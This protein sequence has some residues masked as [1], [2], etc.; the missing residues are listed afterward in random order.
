MLAIHPPARHTS[1][2]Q[3][4]RPAPPPKRSHISVNTAYYPAK[5]PSPELSLHHD[6]QCPS[7]TQLWR[8]LR[9]ISS[10]CC[11]RQQEGDD[12][13]DQNQHYRGRT[14]MKAEALETGD[15]SL[16][17]TNLQLSDS[18][19]YTCTVRT[20]RGGERRVTDIELLVKERFP[21]WAKTLLVLLVLVLIVAAG[22]LYHFQHYFM[23]GESLKLH[24]P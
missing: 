22:L 2:H 4:G 10:S 13:K 11:S 21:S 14:S 8:C 17:L 9:A 12:L 19:T 1:L 6:R 24:Y 3:A 18:G 15:L 20:F 7:R 23:S 16:N 5:T